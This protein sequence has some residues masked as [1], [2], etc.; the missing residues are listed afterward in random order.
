MVLF[1]IKKLENQLAADQVTEKD[2]VNYLITW[3]IMISIFIV[4][5]DDSSYSNL[6]FDFADIF[7]NLLITII[8]INHIFKIHIQNKNS[9]FLKSCISLALVHFWRL[10]LIL[11]ILIIV[12]KSILYV[13]PLD[14][15]L[16]IDGLLKENFTDLLFSICLTLIFYF[17]LINSFKRINEIKLAPGV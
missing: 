17:L 15:F 2:G 16:L 13:I 4:I 12:V 1:N 8:A 9:S 6:W 3:I 5:R 11:T 10:I 14:Y 7:F